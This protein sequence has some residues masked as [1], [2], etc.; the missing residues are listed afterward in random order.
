[1]PYLLD[2]ADEFRADVDELYDTAEQANNG[3]CFHDAVGG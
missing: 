1:L 2:S 3:Y